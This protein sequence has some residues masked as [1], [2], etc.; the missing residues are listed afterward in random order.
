[1]IEVNREN[2]S[3]RSTVETT[4]TLYEN[5]LNSLY[6]N[7]IKVK[8]NNSTVAPVESNLTDMEKI[9][10]NILDLILKARKFNQP[11]V[12]LPTGAVLNTPTAFEKTDND[13]RR[14]RREFSKYI[15]AQIGDANKSRS[16]EEITAMFVGYLG[17]S[18]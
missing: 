1:M 3:S 13:L 5:I 18:I 12:E 17:M 8:P 14:S 16:G 9:T 10:Q 2:C 11:K 15:K 4:E 6:N 7:S